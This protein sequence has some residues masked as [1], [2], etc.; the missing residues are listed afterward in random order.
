MKKYPILCS[1]VLLLSAGS[2]N[3]EFDW[4]VQDVDLLEV[5]SRTVTFSTE[6]SS[7]TVEVSSDVEW[8]VSKTENAAWLTVEKQPDGVVLGV[9]ANSTILSR[10]TALLVEA[11]ERRTE[12]KVKQEG[13]RPSFTS[14]KETMP[15][16]YEGGSESVE[17]TSNVDWEAKTYCDW[18]TITKTDSGL[19]VEAVE[20]TTDKRRVGNVD[21][22]NAGCRFASILVYQNSSVPQPADYY[23]I[24]VS[25]VDWSVSYVHYVKDAK[26][27][28]V[29]VL[30]KENDGDEVGIFMYMALA[31]AADYS[32]RTVVTADVMYISNADGRIYDHDTHEA[33]EQV[34]PLSLEPLTVVSDVKTHGAVKVGEQIWLAEDYKTTKYV[35]GRSIPSYK[36]GQ[37]FWTA[38]DAVVVIHE[39]HHNYTGYTVGWNGS[40]CD[41]S[42]FAPEGWA[43][44]T[45]DQYLEL[46]GA[47]GKNY[48]DMMEKYLF[49]ATENYKFTKDK[50]GKVAAS[51][52][53][54]TNTWT[55]TKSS[56]K[57]VMAGLKPDNSSVNSAQAVTGCF[58]V[59]LIKE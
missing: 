35:D 43:V 11:G 32:V 19:S 49:K 25:A 2:C 31:G 14:S 17:I 5:S 50:S 55:C 29:A 7:R 45:K 51:A 53:G 40:K 46:L 57:L 39:G 34:D 13:V 4:S 42:N 10:E 56:S 21:F 28:L 47:T 44:P 33:F 18:L 6:E 41:Y 38:G 26:G 58:A 16:V 30:T 36:A 9:A 24:D 1:L 8:T 3:S 12:I 15:F 22:Y 52:L 54:Y 23:S 59:R 37:S 48:V 20:N 27:N